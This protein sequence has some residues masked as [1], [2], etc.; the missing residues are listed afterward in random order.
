MSKA[1]AARYVTVGIVRHP[2][3]QEGVV[4]CK[5]RFAVDG[6]VDVRQHAGR[7]VGGTAKH[8]AVDMRQMSLRLIQI[9]YAAIDADEPARIPLLQPVDAGII[10]RR[11]VP[12][13]LRAQPFQPRLARMDPERIRA[14]VEYAVGQ[15][16]E[17]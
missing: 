4:H 11:D 16:V 5:G 17:C 12:V 14:I 1:P 9:R 15:R 8:H 3:D 13:L 7:M 6:A 2:L 10:E